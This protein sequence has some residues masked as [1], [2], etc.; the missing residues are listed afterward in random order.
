MLKNQPPSQDLL[1]IVDKPSTEMDI[2]SKCSPPRLSVI[3][4]EV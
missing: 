1:I 4:A 3:F 2:T